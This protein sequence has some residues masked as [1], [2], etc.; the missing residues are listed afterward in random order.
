ML[1][2]LRRSATSVAAWVILFALVLVFGLN[3]GLPTDTFEVGSAPLVKVYGHRIGDTDYQLQ[4]N[5]IRRTRR[6][7]KDP[8]MQQFFGVK[9]EVL[10]SATE[11]ELL[12]AAGD[13]I[14]LAA[15]TTDAE[16]LVVNGHMIV[17]GDAFDWLQDLNFDYE[18]FTDWF[19]RTLQTS[20]ATY[21]E[22]QRREWLARTVR[23]LIASTAVLSEAELRQLY[24]ADANR[25][26]VRY[27]RFDHATFAE[28]VDPTPAQIDAWVEDHRKELDSAYDAQ[29]S[30]FRKLPKQV[31][32]WVVE[33]PKSGDPAEDAS[34]R[35]TIEDA[36]AE[37]DRGADFRTVA[38]RV[39]SHPSSRSGG[40]LGWTSATVGTGL[41]RVVDDQL[42]GLAEGRLSE[43]LEGEHGWYV[44]RTTG[45]REGDVPREEAIRELADEAVKLSEGKRRAGAAATEA[46]EAVTSGR[47]LEDVF[48]IPGSETDGTSRPSLRETGLFA[49]GEPIPTIGSAPELLEAV[50][51]SEPSVE[52]VDQVFEVEGATILAGLVSKETGSDEGFNNARAQ[53]YAD[54]VERKGALMAAAWATHRCTEAKDMGSVTLAESKVE[55]VLTYAIPGEEDAKPQTPIDLCD[56]VGGRG[57][58]LRPESML[59]VGG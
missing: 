30:R 13:E 6:L 50:W 18:Q 24:D 8:R 33:V 25:L 58:R 22:T 55:R 41:D 23:D 37:I 20:E 39:S 19:L 46:L 21:L 1:N 40:D 7:P 53:L 34:T 45:T 3:F 5:L 4:Y 59:E 51:V 31:R 52:L 57:G 35:R 15:T 12:D 10:A 43:V 2:Y 36:R 26:S 44:V 14:G 56:R 32:V 29:G 9:E 28:L 11:R 54:A 47:P 17:L 16:D 27:A 38:R 49:K 48:A 42:A